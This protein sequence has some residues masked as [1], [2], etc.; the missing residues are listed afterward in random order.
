MKDICRSKG[1]IDVWLWQTVFPLVDRAAHI[2]LVDSAA[3][4]LGCWTTLY[5]STFA[6]HSSITHYNF[7]VWTAAHF[8][9]YFHPSYIFRSVH[10]YVGHLSD[11]SLPALPVLLLTRLTLKVEQSSTAPPAILSPFLLLPPVKVR[12]STAFSA[13]CTDRLAS[14][15]LSFATRCVWLLILFDHRILVRSPHLF[16]DD[17]GYDDA[18]SQRLR[19]SVHCSVVSCR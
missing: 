15:L 12:S 9:S 1:W 3:A 4:G 19:C 7:A 14:R 17:D 10:S 5:F 8:S 13:L 16:D 2:V 6:S 11:L 18:P